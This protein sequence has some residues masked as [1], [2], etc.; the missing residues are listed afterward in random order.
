MGDPPYPRQRSEEVPCGHTR[1][2]QEEPDD[3]GDEER[4][5]DRV[6]G[7]LIQNH[8]GNDLAYEDRLRALRH[9]GECPAGAAHMK[10]RHGHHIHAVSGEAESRARR[11]AVRAHGAVRQHGTLWV[12]GGAGGVELQEAILR[13][14]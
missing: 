2:L 7:D 13:M 14:G 5:G 8:R 4:V 9:R 10:Q 3:G 1:D 11:N 6:A 12:P